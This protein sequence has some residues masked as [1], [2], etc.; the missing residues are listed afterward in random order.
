MLIAFHL[1]KGLVDFARY[2]TRRSTDAKYI[3]IERVENS[4]CGL[5]LLA[6]TAGNDTTMSPSLRIRTQGNY[7]PIREFYSRL[8][9]FQAQG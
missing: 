8:E 6:M 7:I 3:S 9:A 4:Y 5:I 1:G 2:W